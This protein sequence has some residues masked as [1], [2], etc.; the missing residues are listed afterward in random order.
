L[1]AGIIGLLD[2]KQVEV[3]CQ[4]V[5]TLNAIVD[6]FWPEIADIACKLYE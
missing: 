3:Q 1:V 2:E 4:A 6:Y 5:R